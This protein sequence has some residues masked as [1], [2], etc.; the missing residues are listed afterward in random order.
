SATVSFSGQRVRASRSFRS[1]SAASGTAT[2]N[3]RIF[4]T[5]IR[6]SPG[7]HARLGPRGRLAT[8]FEADAFQETA[9]DRTGIDGEGVAATLG[10]GA[11]DLAD[12]P[13]ERNNPACYRARDAACRFFTL[14]RAVLVDLFV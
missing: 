10:I 6:L 14:L 8:A 12:Q 5:R 4:S 11:G 1:S 2:G 13:A 7:N 9:A 3:G